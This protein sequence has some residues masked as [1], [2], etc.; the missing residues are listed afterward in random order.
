[1]KEK[2]SAEIQLRCRRVF[3]ERSGFVA[4]LAYQRCLEESQASAQLSVKKTLRPGA[5]LPC[6]TSSCRPNK[7]DEG[8]LIPK[9][10]P[11]ACYCRAS[12]S[13]FHVRVCIQNVM[14]KV[15]EPF[16]ISVFFC[17]VLLFATAQTA[18][19]AVQLLRE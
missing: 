3:V 6:Q 4:R 19:S 8:T 1:M 13:T 5:R 14:L 16:S 9:Y 7:T 18:G 11:Y 12:P 17:F 2:K 10:F 15:Q